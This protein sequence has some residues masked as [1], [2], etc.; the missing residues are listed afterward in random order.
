MDPVTF[1]AT[2]TLLGKP[3]SEIRSMVTRGELTEISMNGR[4]WITAE[5][6]ARVVA[7]KPDGK[8]G[9]GE[10]CRALAFQATTP[11]A[12]PDVRRTLDGLTGDR[13]GYLIGHEFAQS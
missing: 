4:D 9:L 11:D 10:V 8:P 12:P 1:S 7:G 5:S 13:G 6:L 3:L 2:S